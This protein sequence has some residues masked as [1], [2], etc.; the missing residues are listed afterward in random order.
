MA[1][2]MSCSMNLSSINSVQGISNCL[3]S[4]AVVLGRVSIYS[5]MIISIDHF[6]LALTNCIITSASL[7]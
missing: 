4:R 6:R 3:V 7:E 5:R 2:I 1:A